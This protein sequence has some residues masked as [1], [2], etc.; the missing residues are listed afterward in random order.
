MAEGGLLIVPEDERV[1]MGVKVGYLVGPGG[2]S[3]SR[4]DRPQ[5]VRLGGLKIAVSVG[6]Q[7]FGSD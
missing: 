3:R 2:G 7:L 5:S 6:I 1:F 4:A